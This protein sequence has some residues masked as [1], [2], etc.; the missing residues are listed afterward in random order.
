M[1]QEVQEYTKLCHED[2]EKEL[3]EQQKIVEKY[4]RKWH[5]LRCDLAEQQK[6]VEKYKW[7][8]HFLRCNLA[9][10]QKIVEK[11]K[12]KW[13]FLRCDFICASSQMVLKGNSSEFMLYF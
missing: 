12:R 11:Y 10:Q 1:L 5:F 4:K 13:H 9:E 7:K 2:S 3:A 8:W 6:I